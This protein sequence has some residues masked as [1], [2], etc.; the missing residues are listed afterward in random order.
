VDEPLCHDCGRPITGRGKTGLCLLCNIRK[1]GSLSTREVIDR[2][3]KK[4]RRRR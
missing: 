3:I 4:R 2:S 1:V